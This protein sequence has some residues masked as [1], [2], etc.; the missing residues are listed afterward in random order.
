LT[1]MGKYLYTTNL[2]TN[3]TVFVHDFLCFAIL[4][5]SK[6]PCFSTEDNDWPKYQPV[7]YVSPLVRVAGLKRGS[8]LVYESTVVGRRDGPCNVL[9]IYTFLIS[10]REAKV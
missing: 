2:R 4:Y 5:T 3:R 1:R 6:T 7:L 10:I 9:F 8:K